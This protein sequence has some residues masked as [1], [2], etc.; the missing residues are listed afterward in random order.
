M[1]KL[2]WQIPASDEFVRYMV[3]SAPVT[4]IP[5]WEHQYL[6]HQLTTKDS[7][8]KQVLLPDNA[9]VTKNPIM[10]EGR[11][12]YFQ[13]VSKSWFVLVDGQ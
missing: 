1:A 6:G 2:V 9:F 12:F 5:P 4:F 10:V 11:A 8:A 13:Y 3:P 7:L